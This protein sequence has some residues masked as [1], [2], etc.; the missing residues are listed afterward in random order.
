MSTLLDKS[1]RE[2]LF[3]RSRWRLKSPSP[4][5]PVPSAKSKCSI[6][7]GSSCC[8]HGT[9]GV[10]RTCIFELL[11][12]SRSWKKAFRHQVTTVELT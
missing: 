1:H 11:D 7:I 8:D 10:L 3:L 5:K 9:P 4:P 6:E 12:S 2:F